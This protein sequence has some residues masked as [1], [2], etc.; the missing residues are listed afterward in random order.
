MTKSYAFSGQFGQFVKFWKVQSRKS[1]STGLSEVCFVV[2]ARK[3]NA[4]THAKIRK[5]SRTNVPKNVQKWKT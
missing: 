3:K 4:G 2:V 5:I 1:I